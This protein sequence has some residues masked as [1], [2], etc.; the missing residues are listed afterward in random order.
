M[1]AA[2][3]QSSSSRLSPAAFV[4]MTRSHALAVARTMLGASDD[5]EDVVQE[6]LIRAYTRVGALRD[7]GNLIAWMRQVT[8]TV[9]LNMVRQRRLTVLEPRM[10]E[11]RRD[12]GMGVEEQVVD[13]CLSDQLRDLLAT[14]PDIYAQPIAMYLPGGCRI[15]ETPDPEPLGMGRIHRGRQM[16][17]AEAAGVPPRS[18]E[19]PSALPSRPAGRP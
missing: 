8:R 14:L 1:S 17:C 4:D 11:L 12:E 9:C 5:V 18:S 16:L 19:R 15:A 7:R 13:G 3:I 6:A 2:A 10:V